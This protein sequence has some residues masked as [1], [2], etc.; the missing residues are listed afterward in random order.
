MAK[1]RKLLKSSLVYAVI[2]VAICI[3]L[4]FILRLIPVSRV[5][6]SPGAVRYRNAVW[7]GNALRRYEIEHG[8]RLPDHLSELVPKFVAVSNV[9]WFFWPPVSRSKDQDSNGLEG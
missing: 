8:G 2:G 9:D 3:F 6:T 1:L 4:Y 5:A 7:I